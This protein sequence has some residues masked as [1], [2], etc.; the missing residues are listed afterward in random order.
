M[1]CDCLLVSC[2]EDPRSFW[3]RQKTV[4]TGECKNRDIPA[5]LC[6]KWPWVQIP[7]KLKKLKILLDMM[8]NV[9]N[10]ERPFLRFFMPNCFSK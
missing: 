8:K 1:T 7:K 3:L 2:V 5:K 6:Q 10:S 9:R 4:M